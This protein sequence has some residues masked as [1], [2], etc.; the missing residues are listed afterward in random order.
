M[1][2]GLRLRFA[3]GKRDDQRH[4]AVSHHPVAFVRAKILFVD[5][6]AV[7]R[8]MLAQSREQ[9]RFVYRK[10]RRGEYSVIAQGESSST[11]PV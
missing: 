5:E 2:D 4:L 10:T 11:R 1:R 9:E 7:R 3:F 6:Q 8:Q